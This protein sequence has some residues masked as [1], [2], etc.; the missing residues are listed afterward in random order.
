M[1][2]H[3]NAGRYHQVLCGGAFHKIAEP[4]P[5]RPRRAHQSRLPRA[6]G[7]RDDH[8][9]NNRTAA[10]LD[11]SDLGVGNGHAVDGVLG[12][13]VVG[14]HPAVGLVLDVELGEGLELERR[15]LGHAGRELSALDEP[16]THDVVGVARAHYVNDTEGN[17]AE[18]GLETLQEAAKHV[19]GGDVGLALVV[20][21]V[22]LHEVEAP[23]LGIVVAPQPRHNL[24]LEV[25][26]AVA[27]GLLPRVQHERAL[28]GGAALERSELL[29]VVDVGVTGLNGADQTRQ[30]AETS[31]QVASVKLADRHKVL[32]SHGAHEV[33]DGK[34]LANQEGTAKKEGIG[35]PEALGELRGAGS[36]NL[37]NGLAA[38]AD[39]ETVVEELHP[40]GGVAAGEQL[41]GGVTLLLLLHHV[42]ADGDGAAEGA[43]ATAELNTH[44]G[45][46]LAE[47][48]LLALRAAASALG[49]LEVVGHTQK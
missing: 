36:V 42:A 46:H 12:A 16:D 32:D 31:L 18:V 41:S 13:E 22:V 49:E 37:G 40:G 2:I 33:S 44:T 48:V 20:E 4:V 29:L 19:G 43:E 25:T 10:G 28:G 34:A 30:V 21:L 1:R 35:G 14:D 39:V 38:A 15:V 7:D 23:V 45:L 47:L 11:D 24:L 9:N 6:Q 8:G 26:L 3:K 5:P 17:A 27:V